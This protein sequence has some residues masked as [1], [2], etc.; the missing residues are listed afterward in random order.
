MTNIT[1]GRISSP[2]GFALVVVLGV[3]SAWSGTLGFRSYQLVFVKYHSLIIK[4]APQILRIF[5]AAQSLEA[6]SGTQLVSWNSSSLIPSSG[7]MY[8]NPNFVWKWAY[9][10]LIFGCQK[11]SLCRK[12]VS[13]CLTRKRSLLRLT[14]IATCF[15]VVFRFLYLYN[16]LQVFTKCMASVSQVCK[17]LS[18]LLY[19]HCSGSGEDSWWNVV[20]VHKFVKLHCSVCVKSIICGSQ[21]CCP[22]Q[23]TQ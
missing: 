19:A 17:E 18:S 6:V 11:P 14:V 9:L 4:L 22:M 1:Y 23:S 8:G 3:P 5:K 10:G 12:Q 20:V 21:I 15:S 16:I 13:D 2:T 7:A